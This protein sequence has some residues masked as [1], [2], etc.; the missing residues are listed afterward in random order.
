MSNNKNKIYSLNFYAEVNAE[1]KSEIDSFLK[2]MDHHIE[3]LFSAEDWPKCIFWPVSC[4]LHKNSN[5]Q[6]NTTTFDCEVD[7]E[8]LEG[9]KK[10]IES[11]K[12]AGNHHLEWLINFNDWEL[13]TFYNS[14]IEEAKE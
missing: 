9:D 14:S 11:L 8:V 1:E 4:K 3:Y 2:A 13:W 12:N 10:E 5:E 6:N 7:I